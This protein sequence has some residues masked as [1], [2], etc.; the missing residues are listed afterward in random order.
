M[1]QPRAA[2]RHADLSNRRSG[3]LS[4]HRT[5][6]IVETVANEDSRLIDA[7]LAGDMG[8]FGCLVERH[9][10]RLYNALYRFLGSAEDARD[11]AQ[12]TFLQAL[13]RLRSF[14]RESAFYTWLYR[15]GFNLAISHRRRSKPTVSL[16]RLH[17]QSASEPSDNGAPPEK[18]ALT[19]ERAEKVQ[20]AISRLAEEQRQVV[21]LREIEE[22]SYE[23]IAEILEIPLGTVRSR[24][25]RA[26][27]QLKEHL[28]DL[29][30]EEVQE[31][32]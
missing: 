12:D 15:I 4:V 21:V 25:F 29:L 11:V 9:Q 7:T 18:M 19:A 32:G 31:L 2:D 3:T 23:E 24:L 17:R 14:R 1:H 5:S 8:A 26:R 16:E 28:A 6:Q 27:L 22:R 13:T 10:D 30:R 20:A